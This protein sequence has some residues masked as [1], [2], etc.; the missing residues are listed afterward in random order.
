MNGLF[1]K[2]SKKGKM[3]D[4][5]FNRL[6]PVHMPSDEIHIGFIDAVQVIPVR[7]APGTYQRFVEAVKMQMT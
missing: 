6:A 1:L 4:V 2:K 3:R 7:F 5:S